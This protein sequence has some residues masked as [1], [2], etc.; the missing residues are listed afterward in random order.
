GGFLTQTID[1]GYIISGESHSFGAGGSTWI[2]KTDADGNELWTFN[3]GGLYHEGSYGAIQTFDRGYL[4][5]GWTETDNPGNSNAVVLKL[6]QNGE[7][8]W[9]CL[10]D[11]NTEDIGLGI[12]QDGE[13]NCF[14]VGYTFN[15]PDQ[16]YDMFVARLH[17]V[18]E[19]GV[20]PAEEELPE[21][22]ELSGIYPNPG[23]GFAVVPFSLP[24]AEQVLISMY[25][26]RGRLVRRLADGFYAAGY[27]QV[28]L[29]ATGLSSGTYVILLQAGNYVKAA[30]YTLIK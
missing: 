8:D 24:E 2:I 18:N 6:D 11:L 1:G 20:D 13:G 19:A 28:V 26:C 27:H 23:N 15:G 17:E 9:R 4:L 16:D 3:Y 12:Q 21:N 22:Y 5:A 29:H 30:H 14:M 10:Y 25:D 7:E